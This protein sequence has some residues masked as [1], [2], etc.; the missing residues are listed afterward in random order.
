MLVVQVGGSGRGAGKTAVGCELIRAMP[1]LRWLAV[2][3]SPHAHDVRAGVTEETNAGSAKD[4]GRYLAA[5]AKRAFLITATGDVLETVRHVRMRAKDCD[6]VLIEAGGFSAAEVAGPGEAS[7]T[8]VVLGGEVSEWKPGTLERAQ[9]ADV[10]V[11]ATGMEQRGL[12][13][14][15]HS[16]LTFALSKGEWINA[17]LVDFARKKLGLANSQQD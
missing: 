6:A 5:G 4:T 3:V 12:P 2:K 10:L 16:R 9:G 1:E 15:L 8:L 7:L 17:A 14:E 13:Q 11:S